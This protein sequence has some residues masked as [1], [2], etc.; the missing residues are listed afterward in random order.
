MIIT[1]SRR[2]QS[3]FVEKA[4]QLS[5]VY[6]FSY[7]ER[8][9]L[10]IEAFKAAHQEDIIVVGKDGISI[11][12][13]DEETALF[14]HPNV[15]MIRAKRLLKGEKEA[16][17]SIAKLKEGMSFLDCTLGLAS[18][19]LVASLAVGPNGSVIGIEG[20][21]LLYLLA[22][23]GLASFSSG[24]MTID[25]AMRRIT[26]V[27]CD[28]L[29]FLKKS[30]DRSVDVVYFDPMFETAIAA[31]NGINS[32]RG[33]AIRSD[34][35]KE[36]I[37]EAKRVARQRVVLKDHWKSLR[38]EKLGFIQHVRKTSMFHYGT[39]ERV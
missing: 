22:R 1:T 25:Q 20:N 17:V 2:V 27:N 9:G 10:S 39:I 8:K 29:S 34:L 21:Q 28:H 5:H 7:R 16:L 3:K 30:E 31:S 11:V 35:T 33:Q 38:F 12:P 32:I 13:L 15:A 23:E 24:N 19:S 6:G 4:Y 18:D 37:E 14:F 36:V 26:V